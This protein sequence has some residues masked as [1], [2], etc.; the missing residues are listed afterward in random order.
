MGMTKYEVKLSF[1]KMVLFFYLNKS[2]NHF[3]QQRNWLSKLWYIAITERPM[4][5]KNAYRKF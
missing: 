5:T 4:A 3:Y 2:G 1:P